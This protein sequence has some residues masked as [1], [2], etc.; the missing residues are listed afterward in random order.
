M[1]GHAGCVNTIN[2]NEKGSLLV[3]GSDDTQLCLWSE[4]SFSTGAPAVCF[5]TG[6]R[7]NIFCAKCARP[8]SRL[9]ASSNENVV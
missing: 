5:Q 7:A 3:S 2:W 9:H 1:T 6:H 8:L 4:R